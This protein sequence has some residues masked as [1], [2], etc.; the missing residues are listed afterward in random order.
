[1]SQ[2]NVEI[3]MAL[4]P[5]GTDDLATLFRDDAEWARFSE[6]AAAYLHAD[7][8]L[9][10]HGG[11]ESAHR[12]VGLG[13][14]RVF[15]RDWLSPW[16]AYR[17]EIEEAID[18]GSQVL[19]IV[20]DFGRRAGSTHEV[21]IKGAPMWTFHDDKIVRMEIFAER[22]EALKAVGLEQ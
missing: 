4:F 18:L 2:E 5:W 13:G 8:K 10:V 19:V 16:E 22:S 1:M 15:W 9:I 11:F 3:V 21:E 6:A 17:S 20:R 7:F 14:M 12:Y